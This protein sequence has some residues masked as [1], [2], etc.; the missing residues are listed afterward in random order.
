[1]TPVAASHH[2]AIRIQQRAICA[3]GIDLLL[4]FGSGSPAVEG[5]IAT[6]STT[7]LAAGWPKLST[8]THCVGS[9]NA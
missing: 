7:Q 2:A 3:D 6:T 8:E 1:M 9:R 5:L 4:D